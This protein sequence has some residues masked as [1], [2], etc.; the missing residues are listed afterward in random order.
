MTWSQIWYCRLL[1]W[2]FNH[3]IGSYIN[4]L[5]KRMGHLRITTPQVYL[6]KLNKTILG[7]K[8]SRLPKI[9]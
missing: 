5:I 4:Q 7:Q 9:E 6:V 3:F 2:L 8:T 1:Q